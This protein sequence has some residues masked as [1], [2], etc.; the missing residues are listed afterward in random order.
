MNGIFPNFFVIGAPNAGT[1]SIWYL[2][3]QHPD[4]FMSEVKE[5]RFFSKEDYLHHLS[6]YK[7]LFQDVKKEK[8]I[9]EASVNYCET[10]IFSNMAE[11]IKKYNPSSRFVYVVRDPIDRITSC[12][13]QALSSDHWCKY[14][15]HH[16]L[17][18]LDFEKAVFD[19]PHLLETT[20]YFRNIREYIR[21]FGEDKIKIVF[22]EDLK[23]DSLTLI[24]EIYEFLEVDPQFIPNGLNKPQNQGATKKMAHPSLRTLTSFIYNLQLEPFKSKNNA[25]VNLVSKYYPRVGQINPVWTEGAKQKL[26]SQLQEDSQ[27]LLSYCGKPLKFWNIDLDQ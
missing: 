1:T 26:I 10:H 4:I 18:P 27:V 17:M 11:K 15:Y 14:Y 3:K 12:W 5:P 25:I 20:F 13:R 19:Y 24:Q 22:Y 7:S 16:E 6:W 2:L 9:G 21:L 23:N 8:A